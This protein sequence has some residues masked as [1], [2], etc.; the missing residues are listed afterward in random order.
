MAKL[1]WLLRR[2]IPTWVAEATANESCQ[3]V[4]GEAGG[5]DKVFVG[6]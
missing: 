1:S 4:F 6:N 5:W 3:G 2:R